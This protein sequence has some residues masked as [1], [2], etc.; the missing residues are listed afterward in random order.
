MS[1]LF[2]SRQSG[3]AFDLNASWQATVHTERLMN[4][5]EE[6][7]KIVDSVLN[8]NKSIANSLD[9]ETHVAPIRYQPWIE[10]Y[11]ENKCTLEKVG[12][13]FGV[14]RERVRQILKKYGVNQRWLWSSRNNPHP[15][16]MTPELY[17]ARSKARL[18]SRIDITTDP[19]ECW[20]WT[21]YVNNKL[22]YPAYN[23]RALH[24][25]WTPKKDNTTRVQPI[26]WW[27]TYDKAPEHW[28]VTLCKNHLC[29]NPNH[30]ADLPATEMT[31]FRGPMKNRVVKTHCKRGHEYTPENT[32]VWHGKYDVRCC[33]TCS[34]IRENARNAKLRSASK[35]QQNSS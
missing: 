9:P 12:Q 8:L 24:L 31:R 15:P 20:N 30:L 6:R 16:K 22:G 10:Y 23:V 28:I 35:E 19:E 2:D 13:Q 21:G 32:Y 26:V 11:L 3:V 7:Q 29:C 5:E 1:V 25:P 34:R 17:T 4:H 18:W 14:S 33:R 27:L